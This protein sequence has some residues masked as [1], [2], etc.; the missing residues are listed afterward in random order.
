MKYNNIT[1]AQRWYTRG[2]PLYITA[3]YQVK[4]DSVQRVKAAIDK[5]THYVK[6]N[7]PGTQLYLAWQDKNDLTKFIHFF[8]FADEKAQEIHSNSDAV[9]QFES[10]YSPELV[11]GPVL[12]THFTS[13]AS[14]I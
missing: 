7:E 14:N 2:V 8:I 9:K 4:P 6:E 1:L 10:I 5:F 13:V 3:T 12:F 11:N